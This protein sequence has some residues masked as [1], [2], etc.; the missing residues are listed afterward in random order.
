MVGASIKDSKD[1]LTVGSCCSQT[2]GLQSCYAIIKVICLIP[3]SGKPRC[4]MLV[5]NPNPMFLGKHS[6]PKSHADMP[7][8]AE[9]AGHVSQ[10]LKMPC[11]AGPT[12]RCNTG[13]EQQGHPAP[14]ASLSVT[15]RSI[16]R[17][18]LLPATST[19][20]SPS[21]S[22]NQPMS[23]TTNQSSHDMVQN[24]HRRPPSSFT[25]MRTAQAHAT[26]RPSRLDAAPGDAPGR[27]LT[28][29]PPSRDC[30]SLGL[31]LRDCSETRERDHPTK[32]I[33]FTTMAAAQWPLPSEAMQPSFESL[34]DPLIPPDMPFDALDWDLLTD[35]LPLMDDLLGS[36]GSPS[37]NDS[38]T[39][40]WHG[41]RDSAGSCSGMSE[42]GRLECGLG[43]AR[44]QQP[45]E[46]SRGTKSPVVSM[47]MC[48]GDGQLAASQPPGKDR[49]AQPMT[50]AV[51]GG[52]PDMGAAHK[53][54]PAID[55]VN[56]FNEALVLEDLYLNAPGFTSMLQELAS[57][58]TAMHE[59]A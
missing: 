16:S 8:T 58:D 46:G 23:Q 9:A 4:H 28:G 44:P 30:S 19:Q 42:M 50:S 3:F 59:E 45:E 54:G 49:K 51:D 37:A 36:N 43:M 20:P 35:P 12:R 17:S 5:L 53:Q 33:S 52:Q 55:A 22:F 48:L 27:H 25:S 10:C 6:Q 32:Q 7:M 31:T 34:L 38:L 14:Q 40:A 56:G 13:S 26:S 18:Q 21:A 11:V 57:S 39:P 15:G 29:G 47:D 24:A 41:F 1:G 2:S